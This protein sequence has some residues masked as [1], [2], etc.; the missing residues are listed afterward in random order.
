MRSFLAVSVAV[1][2][3]VAHPTSAFT[4]PSASRVASPAYPRWQARPD[5]QGTPAG[6][7]S[8]CLKL[9]QDE[10]TS[11]AHMSSLSLLRQRIRKT[12]S[13]VLERADTLNAAGLH[14][15]G[16]VP[17]QSGFKSTVLTFTGIMLFKW[18]RARFVTKIPIWDRQPQ[19][20]MVVTKPEHE[21]E[22]HAYECKTCGNIMMI[23]R[24]REWF[25]KGG[26]TECTNC[27]ATGTDNFQDIRGQLLDSID[28]DY[29][30]Y[31]RPLD[32]VS[33]A[34]RRKLIKQAGGDEEKANN[35]L[36]DKA[37]QEQGSDET[38]SEGSAEEGEKCPISSSSPPSSSPPPP[39]PGGTKKQKKEPVDIFDELDMDL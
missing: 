23:A 4:C 31:E 39:S 3:A 8:Q 35:M 19:W 21:K 2:C 13:L 20:N 34:E 6:Q 18:Y 22:L 24:H 12:A 30:D 29:F 25:F 17:M 11:P 27:G 16:A 14:D 10:E 37:E 38:Q 1:A 28:D 5:T 7:C 15:D 33:L 36:I 32:F 26:N 9:T